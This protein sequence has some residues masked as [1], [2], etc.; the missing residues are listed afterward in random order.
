[1]GSIFS[2]VLNRKRRSKSI[3]LKLTYKVSWLALRVVITHLSELNTY[4][5]SP[6]SSN[7]RFR[8]LI[9][10][11]RYCH[12]NKRVSNNPD[13]NGQGCSKPMRRTLSTVLI[14]GPE[15]G[16]PGES[17]TISDLSVFDSHL[18]TRRP[19]VSVVSCLNHFLRNGF[20]SLEIPSR[21]LTTLV[22]KEDSRFESRFVDGPGPYNLIQSILVIGGGVREKLRDNQWLLIILLFVL[23]FTFRSVLPLLSHLIS[24]LV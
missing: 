13:L 1:M 16:L 24:F 5:V 4:F 17:P 10:L 19:N 7:Q 23:S 3:C 6:Y 15:K 22:Y 8:R 9:S 21:G 20:S 11:R 12:P 14:K 2:P 18:K